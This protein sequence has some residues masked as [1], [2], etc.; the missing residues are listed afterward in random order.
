MKSI[1]GKKNCQKEGRGVKRNEG[2][3]NSN[4]LVYLVQILKAFQQVRMH[5]LL[6]WSLRFMTIGDDAIQKKA[7]DK[8]VKVENQ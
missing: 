2:G 3:V 4:P 6:V 5:N 8:E 7:I 1:S